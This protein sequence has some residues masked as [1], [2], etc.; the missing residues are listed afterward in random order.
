MRHTAISQVLSAIIHSA[1]IP[2][3]REVLLSILAPPS[4]TF[5]P[6]PGRMDLVLTSGDFNTILADVTITHPN[7]SQNQRITEAMTLQGHFSVHMERTKINK[8]LDS[9]TSIGA[10]F[11]PLVMETYGN[12]GT[13]FKSFLRA[14]SREYFN[15]AWNYDPDTANELCAK[16]T[17]LWTARLSSVLLR[18][19]ARLRMLKFS[20][21]LL[22]THHGLPTTHM[23]FVE[24]NYWFV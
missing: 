10:R 17:N 7:P 9:A 23:D 21:N 1:Q 16:L 19:N 13:S 24:T 20:R 12:F 11:I 2:V 22:P 18:A 15:R 14:I 8:Y 4:A 6:P 5:S 3:S